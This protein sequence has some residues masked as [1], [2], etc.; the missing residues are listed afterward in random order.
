MR[1]VSFCVRGFPF[2]DMVFLFVGIVF[3]FLAWISLCG[4]G[5]SLC[6]RGFFVRSSVF[7][8]VDVV[9][10]LPA[11]LTLFERRYPF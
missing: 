7:P 1:V 8:F 6:R 2:L 5:F 4:R 11:W 10:L 9:F 3:P